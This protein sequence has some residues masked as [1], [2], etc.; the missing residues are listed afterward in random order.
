[1]DLA[2]SSSSSA[3][4]ACKRSHYHVGY[5]LII[6]KATLCPGTLYHDSSWAYPNRFPDQQQRLQHRE[7]PTRHEQVGRFPLSY[8]V[9]P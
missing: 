3:T 2:A 5:I 1:M 6:F 8:I 9:R 4:E 7:E